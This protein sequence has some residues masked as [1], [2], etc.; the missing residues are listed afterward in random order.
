MGRVAGGFT[1]ELALAHAADG[2]RARRERRFD[3]D[4]NRSAIARRCAARTRCAVEREEAGHTRQHD[5]RQKS[6]CS[7][8][9]D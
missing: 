6:S 7:L 4:G 3:A 5:G 9:H 8:V 1:A 2:S